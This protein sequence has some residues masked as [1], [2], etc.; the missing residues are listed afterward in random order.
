MDSAIGPVRTFAFV[1]AALVVFAHLLPEAVAEIGFPALVVFAASLAL[2]AALE[3]FQLACCCACSVTVRV[4][5]SSLLHS[6]Q[7]EFWNR[8]SRH[9]PHQ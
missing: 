6:L 7:L 1:A 2:P 8:R 3:C 5:L 4:L 9:R